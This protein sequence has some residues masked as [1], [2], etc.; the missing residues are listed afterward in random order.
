MD[1]YPFWTFGVVSLY[2][3]QVASSN[4]PIFLKTK[5]AGYPSTVLVL[6]YLVLVQVRHTGLCK[7]EFC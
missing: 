1:F 2:G 7:Y 4:I 5:T 6:V 3:M